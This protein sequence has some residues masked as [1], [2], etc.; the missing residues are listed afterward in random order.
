MTHHFKYDYNQDNGEIR[1]MGA[2]QSM[3]KKKGHY[4]RLVLEYFNVL[5]IRILFF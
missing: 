5:L 1:I 4:Q 3:G 2:L